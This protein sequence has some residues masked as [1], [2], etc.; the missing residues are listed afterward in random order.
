MLWSLGSGLAGHTLYADGDQHILVQQ[1]LIL[2]Q[3]V[4]T[5][6]S[7]GDKEKTHTQCQRWFQQVKKI[8]HKLLNDGDMF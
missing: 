1:A 2:P 6:W 8:S 7:A 5:E 4:Q 3:Y